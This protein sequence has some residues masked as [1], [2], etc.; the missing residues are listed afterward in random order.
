MLGIILTAVIILTASGPANAD[1]N[2]TRSTVSELSAEYHI[3]DGCVYRYRPSYQKLD[4]PGYVVS[5]YSDG[6]DLY[7]ITIQDG[8]LSAGILSP[9]G[10]YIFRTGI[11]FNN[12]SRVKLQVNSGVFYF[13]AADAERGERLF[14]YSAERNVLQ[15]IDNIDDFALIAG[16]I[17]VVKGGVISYK[18]IQIPVMLQN[19]YIRNVIDER[20][21]VLSDGTE[22][23]ICDLAA[24]R[25]IYQYKGDIVYDR[26]DDFNIILE[27]ADLGRVRTAEHEDEKMVYYNVTVNGYDI[28]RTETGPGTLVKEIH[29]KVVAGRQNIINAERWELDRSRGRYVRVNNINQ[30]EELRVFIPFNRVVKLS[31]RYNGSEHGVSQ[32]VFIK[33][34]GDVSPPH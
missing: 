3:N 6:D 17:L 25:S 15:S 34:E 28:G 14:R 5:I 21:V 11:A 33:N 8:F 19:T 32:N 7:F 13:S 4:L 23:E 29:A 22:T 24:A 27:F 20:I 10:N 12:N 30:P 31:F 16:N 2:S 26:G 18:G 1:L 9:D